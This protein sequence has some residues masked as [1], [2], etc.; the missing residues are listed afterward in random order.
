MIKDINGIH[1][2]QLP[3]PD[4]S[5]LSTANMYLLTSR[6]VTLIDA[7]PKYPGS[8]EF[9]KEGINQAGYDTSDLDRILVTHGHVD[10]FGLFGR[11]RE[12]AG[13]PI[14]CFV[15]PEDLWRVRGDAHRKEMLSSEV[16][17]LAALA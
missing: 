13:Q 6:P 15:H 2:I 9:I 11:I 7:T 4:Y 5:D 16:A 17:T 8:F 10:H 3:L 12:D 14:P 1:T